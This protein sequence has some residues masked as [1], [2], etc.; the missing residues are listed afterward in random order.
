MGAEGVEHVA[1]ALQH[2]RVALQFLF[3]LYQTS[4]LDLS[5]D[6]YRTQPGI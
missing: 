2:N 6:T 5:I 3:Y 4:R 1:K